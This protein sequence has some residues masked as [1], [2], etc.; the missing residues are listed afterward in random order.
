MEIIKQ[1]TK[2]DKHGM[3]FRIVKTE[4]K[5]L[6]YTVEHSP[7]NNDGT[8]NTEDFSILGG[9][10]GYSTSEFKT[11]E[12]ARSFFND[13]INLTNEEMADKYPSIWVL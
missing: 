13:A 12:E 5:E 4:N 3:V 6:P 7:L 10:V 9:T 11:E 2:V 1:D 8:Y